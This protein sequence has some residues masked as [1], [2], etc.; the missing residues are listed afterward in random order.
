MVCSKLR[1]LASRVSTLAGTGSNEA[2][3]AAIAYM[4]ELDKAVKKRVIHPNAANRRKGALS[5][6]IFT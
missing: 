3:G 4:S 6:V 5:R 1:T 2:R